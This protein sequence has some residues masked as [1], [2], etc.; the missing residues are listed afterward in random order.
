VVFA[1][2]W[3]ANKFLKIS[4][5]DLQA[6]SDPIY[7]CPYCQAACHGPAKIQQH[8]KEMHLEDF[9]IVYEGGH[10]FPGKIDDQE[11]TKRI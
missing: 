5:Q 11:V 7:E 4:L 3:T 6:D 1:C 10:K 2:I 9:E 8:L